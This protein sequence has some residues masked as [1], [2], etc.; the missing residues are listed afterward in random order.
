[1]ITKRHV[2]AADSLDFHETPPEAVPSLLSHDWAHHL[3]VAPLWE[4]CA[5]RGAILNEL[6]GIND[7]VLAE[8][9]AEYPGQ[10]S[11]IRTGRDF[12]ERTEYENRIIVTN[13]P[14]NRADDFIRHAITRAPEAWLLL[15]WAYAEGVRKSDIID[16]HLLCLYPSSLS[17]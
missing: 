10:D 13:P 4:P 3:H 15:R 5:G 6:V 14:F 8:D 16:N 2:R 11:R 12:F 1:M 17:T 7:D 9:I